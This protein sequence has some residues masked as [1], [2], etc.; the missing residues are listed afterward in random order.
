M[1]ELDWTI[2]KQA[3]DEIAP[4]QQAPLIAP[5]N[6]PQAHGIE[7]NSALPLSLDSPLIPQLQTADS[8]SAPLTELGGAAIFNEQLEQAISLQ[9]YEAIPQEPN[10]DLSQ[11]LE[12]NQDLN[13]SQAVED[14]LDP[15]KWWLTVYAGRLSDSYLRDIIRHG[16]PRDWENSYDVGVGA[17]RVLYDNGRN[18][19]LEAEGNA[20]QYL[21]E[22]FH[23]ELT[24]AVA[25]RWH[26]F[27][28]DKKVDTSFALGEGF[29]WQSEN[30]KYED[31][32]NKDVSQWLNYLFLEFTFAR[33]K[34]PNTQLVLRLHHR[35]G[36]YG[37]ING[38]VG[39]S[40]L[41][42]MG[43]RFRL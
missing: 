23:Q 35:S 36:V 9:A 30:S 41:Y 3:S 38:V 10:S 43:V 26:S 6:V 39:G 19:S 18:L 21:G 20:L 14:E 25:L 27:P 22:Q 8:W 40:N 7:A 4:S 29:S 15:G 11:D 17:T 5:A 33:P 31:R 2:A 1:D 24:S 42:N 28:W 16:G 34:H 37:L 13:L 32:V 12:L